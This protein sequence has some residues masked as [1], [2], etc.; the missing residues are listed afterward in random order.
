MLNFWVKKPE[1]R[2]F[3]PVVPISACA[4]IKILNT[5]VLKAP[6]K[7]LERSGGGARGT[8]L[9]PVLIRNDK[10]SYINRIRRNDNLSCMNRNRR[11][12]KQ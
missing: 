6:Q 8:S 5:Y 7:I 4:Y 9:A 11:C 12:R 1:N 2:D 3:D 10:L